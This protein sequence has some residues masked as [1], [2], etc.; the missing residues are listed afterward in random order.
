[1]P[2][3]TEDDGGY[4]QDRELGRLIKR[5]EPE[6]VTRYTYDGAGGGDMGR[7][8]KVTAPGGYTRTHTYDAAGR[9]AETT[10]NFDGSHTYQTAYDTY[11]RVSQV[12]Y[13]TGY[14]VSH[15]YNTA[16]QLTTVFSDTE[17]LWELQGVD[18]RGKDLGD[19]LAL[20]DHRSP[21]P[22]R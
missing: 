12:T 13:P 22:Q 6:G 15:G 9:P 14:S 11:G 10:V 17:I 8:T 2:Y 16:G 1:M 20:G 5:S 18:A 4:A 7:L 3:M 21:A 19:E